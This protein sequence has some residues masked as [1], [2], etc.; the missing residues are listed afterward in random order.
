MN[1]KGFT[2]EDFQ[3]FEI[4]GL[5]ARMDGIITHIRPKFEELASHFTPTLSTYTGDEMFYHVAKHARRTVNPPKDTWVAFAANKRG[6]KQH[7]HFQIGLWGTHLFVWYALIYE[8]PIKSQYGEIFNKQIKNLK[9][10][11]PGDFV[12]SMDHM[13]PGATKHSEMSQADLEH[14]GDRLQQ[15]KKS[16]LLCGIQIDRHDPILQNGEALIEKIDHTF[17]TLLPLYHLSKDI[18]K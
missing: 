16:E 7:P 18:N 6:Y 5:E 4:E 11:I 17:K 1:F 9:E 13:K 14:M 15:V 2:Q 10:K 8:A 3:V 12:W